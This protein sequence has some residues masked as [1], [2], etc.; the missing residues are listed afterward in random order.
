M[1]WEPPNGMRQFVAVVQ[2]ASPDDAEAV[3]RLAFANA[4]GD[5]LF[6]DYRLRNAAPRLLA[7]CRLALAAVERGD[8]IDWTELTHAI[9]IAEPPEPAVG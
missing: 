9:A 8:A 6:N 7:A 1:P 4:A 3:L 5:A 2:N